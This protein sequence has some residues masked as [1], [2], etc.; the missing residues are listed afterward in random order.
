MFNRIG[1]LTVQYRATLNYECNTFEA[2]EIY[3]T[4]D[5]LTRSLDAFTPF[6]SERLG[7]AQ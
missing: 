1:L 6:F 7:K 4:T 3:M 5:E 2:K